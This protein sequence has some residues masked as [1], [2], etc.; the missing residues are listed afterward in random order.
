[1]G[2]PKR[3]KKN[4]LAHRLLDVSSGSDQVR[5]RIPDRLVLNACSGVKYYMNS[6]G[7]A[8]LCVGSG[9]CPNNISGYTSCV[10]RTAPFD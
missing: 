7:E 6:P 1:M 4:P 3:L 5:I 9:P 8:R 2:F 10:K